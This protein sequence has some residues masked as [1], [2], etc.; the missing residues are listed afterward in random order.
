MIFAGS[1]AMPVNKLKWLELLAAAL[2]LATLAAALALT[3]HLVR[4]LPRAPE[5]TVGRVIPLN[6]HGTFVYLTAAEN[7]LHKGLFVASAVLFGGAVLI[8]LLADPFRRRHR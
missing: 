2:A 6:E 4:T 5:P 7:L 8:D 1:E 3:I